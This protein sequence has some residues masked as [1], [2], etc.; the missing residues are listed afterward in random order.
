MT[1]LRIEPARTKHVGTVARRMRD[2]DRRECAAAGHSPKQ[3]LREAVLNSEVAWTATVGDRP[4]AM[5]GLVVNSVLTG[6]GAPW[7]LGT[8]VVW[9][10]A[11]ALLTCAPPVLKRFHDS[12]PR[13]S[14]Y[15]SRENAAAIR[16]LERWGFAVGPEGRT[17]G[18][19]EFLL[20]AKDDPCASL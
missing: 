1:D 17:M 4:E 15:V 2:I 19:V 6:E 14:G 10:H 11:R 3:A 12:T 7:F 9:R 5:F 20:F 8:D 18:G 13:L 16:L